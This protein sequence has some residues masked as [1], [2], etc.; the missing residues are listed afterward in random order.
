MRVISRSSRVSQIGPSIRRHGV[1]DEEIEA[2]EQQAPSVEMFED[3]SEAAM[4][5]AMQPVRM[6]W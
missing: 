5:A 2:F 1:R 6:S 4:H 3:P